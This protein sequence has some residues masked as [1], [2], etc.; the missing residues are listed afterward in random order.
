MG[1]ALATYP[2]LCVYLSPYRGCGRVSTKSSREKNLALKPLIPPP[3]PGQVHV[4]RSLVAV[5]E[6]GAACDFTFQ[7]LPPPPPK[8]EEVPTLGGDIFDLM[9]PAF[10]QT[11]VVVVAVR[12]PPP[13]PYLVPFKT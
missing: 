12:S 1:W 4:V 13:K 3:P 7:P 5:M 2:Q 11:A 6:Y 10:V 8:V 9:D